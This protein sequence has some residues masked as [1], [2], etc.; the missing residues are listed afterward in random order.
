M[1]TYYV[2][3]KVKFDLKKDNLSITVNSK[4]ELLVLKCPLFRGFTVCVILALLTKNSSYVAC[5]HIW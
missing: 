3:A 5:T 2:T 4:I 1:E